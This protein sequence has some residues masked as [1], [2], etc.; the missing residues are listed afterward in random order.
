MEAVDFHSVEKTT[1]LI[2][3]WVKERTKGKI[4]NLLPPDALDGGTK[5]ALVNAAYFK[6]RLQ[7]ATNYYVK[8]SQMKLMAN[9]G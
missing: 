9:T 1:G 8:K 3:G 6:V 5:M 7:F 4:A 2:N